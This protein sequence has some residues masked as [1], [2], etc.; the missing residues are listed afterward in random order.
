MGRTDIWLQ[1]IYSCCSSIFSLHLLCA[2]FYLFMLQIL[3]YRWTAC[4]LL[5]VPK[6]PRCSKWNWSWGTNGKVVCTTQWVN[7]LGRRITEVCEYVDLLLFNY[8]PW[9]QIISI[10]LTVVIELSCYFY[11]FTCMLVLTSNDIQS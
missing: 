8:H 4:V 2:K 6:M 5:W 10:C 9:V 1:V 11:C 7:R 3:L